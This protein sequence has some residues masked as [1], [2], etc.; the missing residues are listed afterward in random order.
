MKNRYNIDYI[1]NSLNITENCI[2]DYDY[3][4]TFNCRD[5][6]RKINYNIFGI[7]IVIYGKQT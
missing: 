4:G 3:I 1:K 7:N 5:V 2:D 6:L